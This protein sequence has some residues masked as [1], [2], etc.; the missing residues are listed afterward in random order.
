MYT[1]YQVI[2]YLYLHISYLSHGFFFIY[3]VS[4][5]VEN[6]QMMLINSCSVNTYN[7]GVPKGGVSSVFYSVILATSCPH[8][9]ANIVG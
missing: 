9:Q 2:N 6:L 7:L 8:L 4:S 5:A 1:R 3:S